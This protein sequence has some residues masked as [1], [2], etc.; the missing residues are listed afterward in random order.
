VQPSAN[1]STLRR[2]LAW[3]IAARVVMSS[4]LLGS[5]ALFQ[6]AVPRA[7]PVAPFFY[8]I[9]LTYALT[10]A[11]LSM[12]GMADR[13]R[14]I[15]DLQL[16][17]DALI[18]SAFIHLTGGINSSFSVLYILP[19]VA[20]S[21]IQFRRGGLLVAALSALLYGGVVL[22]QYGGSS[23]IQ[24]AWPA[25]PITLPPRLTATYIVVINVFGFFAVAFL[26]GSLAEGL[27]SAGA[28]LHLA[29]SQIADLRALNEH[30]INS[31]PSGLATTDRSQLVVTFNRTAEMITG[32]AVRSARDRPIGEILQLPSAILDSLDRDLADG[33]GRRYE[34]Y[35]RTGDGRGEIELGMTATHLE[36]PGGRAGFLFTFQD[37][38]QIKKLERDAAMQQ[39]LAAVG[40]MAAGIAHEIRNPLASMSG[41]IQI[42]RQE[43][44]LTAEQEQLFDIV[45]RE[46]DRLNASIQSFLAY[47]RPQ[48][49]AIARFDVRRTLNDAA[50]LLRNS[51]EV[52]E[53]HR[54]DVDL[55][56]DELWY[57]A[58]E[59]QIK[60]IIWN[61]ATNGLRAMPN[62]GRLRLV[63]SAEPASNGVIISVEDAGI[64]IP[65]EDLDGLFQPF[66]G[67]FP[68]GSGLGLAIV[69]RIVSDYNGEIRVSSQ[70]G[71]GTTV[72]VLLPAR[73]LVATT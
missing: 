68:T 43:L 4:I 53:L 49:F 44:L 25:G 56:A 61:L 36:T 69:H 50:L 32:V 13:H 73:R 67:G 1:D 52:R 24:V 12:L 60:Q 46:S 48:R 54:V 47:A 45:L 10:L 59:G 17:I 27:R 7:L 20:A 22:N 65:S 23:L 35:Y 19:I 71:T 41:S 11:Y 16:G 30:V 62:G 2:K 26:S 34:F 40:E 29:S 3:L 51:S 15:L 37:V 31:L 5:A 72:S 6:I 28:R 21:T 33:A 8:L 38:T 9:G 55:P 57:D 14:W 58:D 64:G 18:V 66:H 63:G 70:V 39:R 42:L